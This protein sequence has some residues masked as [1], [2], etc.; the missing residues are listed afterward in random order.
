MRTTNAA[1]AAL[2]AL[3]VLTV[4]G[5]NS[6]TDV[7]TTTTS[8]SS[9]STST[10]PSPSSTSS[11]SST[12]SA[13]PESGV[14]SAE[15][16]V[17]SFYGQ[18]DELGQGKR[19]IN[20]VTTWSL[21]DSDGSDTRTKWSKLVG[22]Q[23]YGKKILQVGSTVVTDVSGKEVAKPKSKLDLLAAYSVVAC[24]DR[25]GLTY[26]KN[27]SPVDLGGGAA[28]KSIVTHLVIQN[29]GG[30]YVVRDEPGASC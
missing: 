21:I 11:T 24:V 10:T 13:T 1:V 12:S 8:T 4:S 29:K 18:M 3:G 5:C 25:S 9:S 30:Y 27:G 7:S 28:T 16:A 23:V 17:T 22:N 14:A 20:K 6:G 15:Q 19:D 26:E 2:I